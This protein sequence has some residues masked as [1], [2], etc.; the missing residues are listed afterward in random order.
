MPHPEWLFTRLGKV[1]VDTATLMAALGIA[2]LIRFDGA[3]PPDYLT[4]TLSIGPYIV[5]LTLASLGT[6]GAYNRVWRYT[7]LSDAM[8]LTA[9][10]AV[11][12]IILAVVRLAV[13]DSIALVRVPF[14]V[15]AT[16]FAIGFFGTLT[17]RAMWRFVY[18]YK[19]HHGA[20]PGTMRRILIVGADDTGIRLARDL[21][22]RHDLKVVGFIDDDRTRARTRILG[23]PVRGTTRDLAR[24]VFAHRAD[25]IIVA[26]SLPERRLRAFVQECDAIPVRLRVL[27][28]A[29]T[30]VADHVSGRLRD[31]R[32]EDLLPRQ[33]ATFDFGAPTLVDAYRDRRILITGA[34]GS[35]GS[36]LCRRL[37]A[38]RPAK[39]L[40]LDHDEDEPV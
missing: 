27:A 30:A 16:Y 20:I 40:L 25:E 21:A 2:Y 6:S 11:P 18:E 35:I 15:T 5:L 10:L 8:G 12:A 31:V 24:A 7:N 17:V 13:P 28:P 38:L 32:L 29:V 1:V 36:E 26:C 9:A 4:Q 3:I 33:V 34:G 23:V 14:S 37:L 22:H 39:L 19:R